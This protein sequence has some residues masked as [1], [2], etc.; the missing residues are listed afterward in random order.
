MNQGEIKALDDYIALLA[1]EIRN[2]GLIFARM[3]TVTLASGKNIVLN[4]NDSKNLSSITATP[5]L[6]K[7]LI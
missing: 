1:P 7:G 3:G 5:S 2:E 4:F 6:I